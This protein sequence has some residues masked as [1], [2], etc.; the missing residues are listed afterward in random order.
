MVLWEIGLV[1][2]AIISFFHKITRRVDDGNYVNVIHLTFYNMFDL[3]PQAFW[4]K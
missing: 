1:K 3:V 4:L 2:Q